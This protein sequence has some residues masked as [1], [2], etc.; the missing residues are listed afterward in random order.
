MLPPDSPCLSR[1]AQPASSA[2]HVDL[3]AVGGEGCDGCQPRSRPRPWVTCSLVPCSL[4][5]GPRPHLSPS[6][7]D[8]RCHLSCGPSPAA[9]VVVRPSGERPGPTLRMGRPD[10]GP[11]SHG[12]DMSGPTPSRRAALGLRGSPPPDRPPPPPAAGRGRAV[13]LRLGGAHGRRATP[14]ARH[15]NLQGRRRWSLPGARGTITRTGR[16]GSESDDDP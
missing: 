7:T 6:H 16:V 5:W 3:G 11:G 2:V 12:L 15:G 13:P 10:S 9:E 1:K 8:A 4:S 14:R